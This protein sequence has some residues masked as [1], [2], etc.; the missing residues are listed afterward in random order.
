ML[1]SVAV[2]AGIAA[3]DELQIEIYREGSDAGDTFTGTARLHGVVIRIT[4]NAAVAA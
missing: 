2:P 1:T 4:T 3:G